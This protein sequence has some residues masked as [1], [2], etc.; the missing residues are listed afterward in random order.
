MI[1]FPLD[2]INKESKIKLV[3]M[4][5]E[6]EPFEP[7]YLK[8]E[9]NFKKLL[10]DQFHKTDKFLEVNKGEENKFIASSSQ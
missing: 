3:V 1:V 9:I 10:K 5:F 7:I 8:L 4:R 6:R 2:V